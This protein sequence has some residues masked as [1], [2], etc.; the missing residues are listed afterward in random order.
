MNV[1]KQAFLL[2]GSAGVIALL[3]LTSR[4]PAQVNSPNLPDNKWLALTEEQFQNGHYRMA[5]QSAEQYLRLNY[6]PLHNR[7]PQEL[8][9]ATY[10]LVL[11]HLRLGDDKAEEKALA[12]VH[13]TSN[14]AYQQRVSFALAQFYFRNGRLGE[15]I[16]YYEEANIANLSNREIADA[17][18]EQAYCYFNSKQFDKAESLFAS[19][20]EVQGKYY[21]A[22]NYYYGLLAYNKSNYAEALTSFERI[23][24]EPQYRNIVPYYVAEIHYFMGNRKK[25]LDE[26]QR[27][28][29]R[30]DK[31]YYNNE[32]HLLA[33]QCL[34]EEQRYG[35]ALPYFEQYYAS[36]D[37]IRKEELYEMGYCYYRVN[38]W[39]NAV[40]KFKPLSN[41]QDS[42]GQTAMYLLGDCYLKT[43]DKKSARNAFG[44]CADMP[45][46]QGQREASLIL[47]ARL[48]YEL[49]YTDDATR[50]VS[51]L[52]ADYPQSEYRSEAK[53][54]LSDL[55]IKNNNYTQALAT[56]G[57]VTT[58]DADYWRVYQK[59]MYGHGI[60]Q[61]QAGN[62]AAA[63]SL[64]NLSLAQPTDPAYEA[65]AH[66]WK[67]DIA[68]RSGRYP[69]A[70]SQSQLFLDK[71]GGHERAAFLSPM[72]TESHA[73]LNMGYASLEQQ[74]FAAA[75][76]YFQLAQKTGG[77]NLSANAT[78]READAVFMQKEF[79]RALPLYEKVI[80]TGGEDAD[81]ARFQKSILLGLQ[82]KNAEKASLLQSLIG[83]TPASVYANDARYELAVTRIEQDQYQAAIDLLEPLRDGHTGRGLAPRAW[84][85]TAFAYEELNR[86]EDAIAAYRKVV[87]DFPNTE[88][89]SGAL[90]ALKS[91]YIQNNQPDAYAQ[92]LKDNNIAAEDDNALDSAYYSAAENQFASGNWKSSKEALDKYLQQYPQGQFS[93]KAHYYKA[94]SHYNLKE[95]DEA[96]KEYDA[97]LL[98]PWSDFTENSAR[99][100]AGIAFGKKDYLSAGIYYEKLRNSAMGKENLQLAYSGLMKSAWELDKKEDAARYADTLLSLPELDEQN[101]TEAQLVRARSLQGSSPDQALA[102]YK[103]IAATGK[104]SAATAEARYRVSEIL[105]QQ[106]KLK[107]AEEA[108][109]NT[110][111][112]SGG[113]DRWIVKS[114]ILLADVLTKQK[115]YFNAKATLQ[116]IV[117]NTK[118]EELK[119]EAA[120]K[121]EEVQ[122][123]E[124]QQSKLSE[125]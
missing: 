4:A 103:E 47:N 17:K 124:K 121:L 3:L 115:D 90:E 98:Y 89:R 68:Y 1:N 53:T 20:K 88:E 26:A 18:F 10:Y 97:V 54:L 8:D 80:A 82:G 21:S 49:G 58:R 66:F 35:D 12:Y 114:Y 32:L 92:L 60:Q 69:E 2:R 6:D 50:R 51:T 119:A 72:V 104:N 113:H 23:D 93:G 56:L 94:E 9:K 95:Y 106:N 24:E 65:A 15:A 59:V 67:G 111:Q 87:T 83:K 85:R 13:T 71:T 123:L 36:T 31:L 125:E 75:Q 29:K 91:L 55:L 5:V 19:I 22:G 79:G 45:F 7:H 99:R 37:K 43:G 86:K 100:A 30:S 11:S 96:L 109:G 117:K 48:S 44:I 57:E 14:P 122:Q 27:L 108:A 41:T 46:N 110:I 73:Y 34:F 25:A 120:R 62:T 52:I 64:L 116:S 61:M 77:S 74:D 105:L 112:Q 102:V 101:R 70:L 76:N 42:L 28:I 107:E 63:D 38:E 16:P 118:I 84:M 78:L 40:E 39:K 33:A 81:Y